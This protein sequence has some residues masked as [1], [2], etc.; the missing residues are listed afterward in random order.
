MQ[1]VD[2]TCLNCKRRIC[3]NRPY[4]CNRHQK[5]SLSFLIPLSGG[6]SMN[7]RNNHGSLK[8]L[9]MW[10]NCVE[11]ELLE[12]FGRYEC[13]LLVLLLWHYKRVLSLPVMLCKEICLEYAKKEM[14]VRR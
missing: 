4:L 6:K 1:I 2:N 14:S 5:L 10:M 7:P 8:V 3:D 11:L 13:C 12:S 9:F